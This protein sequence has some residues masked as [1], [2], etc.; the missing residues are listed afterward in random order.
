MGAFDTDCGT[1]GNC[2]PDPTSGFRQSDA[3]VAK[4]NPLGSALIYSTYLGGS[5]GDSGIG[6]AVDAFGNAEETKVPSRQYSS[7]LDREEP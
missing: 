5:E 4:L 7:T 3:F 2:N 1:D 6:L